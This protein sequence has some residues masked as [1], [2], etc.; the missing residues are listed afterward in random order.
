MLPNFVKHPWK[1]LADNLGIAQIAI[2][3]HPPRTQPALLKVNL[4]RKW[5]PTL[6]R[7]CIGGWSQKLGVGQAGWLACNPSYYNYDYDDDDDDDDDDDYSMMM[8][9]F[10]KAKYSI[11]QS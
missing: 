2:A 1:S 6:I 11:R 5:R 3:P 8:T 7:H 10:L 4:W 9:N